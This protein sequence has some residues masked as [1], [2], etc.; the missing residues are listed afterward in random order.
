MGFICFPGVLD[1]MDD[2]MSCDCGD[3]C[4]GDDCL[5]FEVDERPIYGPKTQF[6]SMVHDYTVEFLVPRISEIIFGT[7]L[8]EYL[9]CESIRMNHPPRSPI[10]Y[11]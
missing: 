1:Y 4:D 6:E 3:C 8:S 10:K 7:S 2:K 5:N 9:K 11:E